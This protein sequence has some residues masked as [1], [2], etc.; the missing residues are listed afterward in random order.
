MV[1]WICLIVFLCLTIGGVYAS[2]VGLTILSIVLTV[3][4]AIFFALGW[5]RYKDRRESGSLKG[6]LIYPKL[7]IDYKITVNLK[8]LFGN[9]KEKRL[10]NFVNEN[11][12]FTNLTPGK[13]LLEIH[14]EFLN[15]DVRNVEINKR[16]ITDIGKIPLNFLYDNLFVK[17]K[18]PNMYGNDLILNFNGY[19]WIGGQKESKY[20]LYK[21]KIDKEEWNEIR[22]PQLEG[23][24]AVTK[25]IEINKQ[26]LILGTSYS[27]AII[28][29][30]GGET[31]KQLV[32][33]TDVWYVRDGFIMENGN[34]I[35]IVDDGP[36][37]G[38]R[39]LI[40]I[41]QDD[42]Q[43]W[44]KS[45]IEE[46][47][48]IKTFKQVTKERVVLGTGTNSR[49]GSAAGIFYSENGLNW[50][51]ASFNFN[52]NK[53]IKEIT[54]ITVISNGN[55]LA[56]TTGGGTT[57][58][59]D[60]SCKLLLSEDNGESWTVLHEDKRWGN[61]QW[62][63]ESND[64]L[65]FV[66]SYN[67]VYCSVDFGV[68]W[69]IFYDFKLYS[70]FLGEIGKSFYMSSQNEILKGDISK[71]NIKKYMTPKNEDKFS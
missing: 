13:Y 16:T 66:W 35:F 48:V 6:K 71:F 52:K 30:D 68:T 34:W 40:L 21:R 60:N 44:I 65:L 4:G 1:A 7:P 15:T 57:E 28:T 23:A 38:D 31:W 32:G 67:K 26:C 5:D 14:G 59:F 20:L 37:Y 3:L 11:F 9:K 8:E 42:G 41:S 56:G 39:N 45:R 18:A 54:V 53:P 43:T 19:D 10:N 2:S 29:Y 62:I 49:K 12:K 58:D 25:F 69:D 27:G 17:E 50:I 63:Y 55:L 24:V 46:K 36:K 47:M 22:I 70:K 33:P 51:R 61:I 64:G